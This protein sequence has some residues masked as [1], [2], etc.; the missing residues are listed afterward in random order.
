MSDDE[1][2]QA[3]LDDATVEDTVHCDLCG[4]PWVLGGHGDGIIVQP[5]QATWWALGGQLKLCTDCAVYVSR[6]LRDEL[7]ERDV[8]EHGVLCGDWCEPCNAA[9]KQ[10]LIDNGVG[11]D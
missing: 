9:H 5:T 3:E 8:C 7:A 2:T 10:A 6:V 11:G 4:A 1:P